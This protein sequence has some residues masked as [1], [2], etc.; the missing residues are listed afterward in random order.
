MSGQGWLSFAAREPHEPGR[1][2]T[3]LELL[4]DLVTVIAVAAAARGLHHGIAEGHAAEAI[5]TY[6]GAFFAIWWA[7]MNYTWFASAYGDDGPPFRILTMAMMAGSL[8]MAAGIDRFM[9]GLDLR[10]VVIGYIIMRFCM[11]LLW[12]AAARGD[13]LR[14]NTALR[15]AAGIFIAQLYW[16]IV[17]PSARFEGAA[18]AALFLL[19]IAIELSVPWL[20]EHTDPTP[21]HRHHI[22]ERYGLLMIIVFGE[23]LLSAS[24]SIGQALSQPENVALIH[25]PIGAAV[26]LFSLWWAYFAREEHLSRGHLG[27]ALMWGYGHAV[28]FASGAAVGAGIAVLVDIVSG[29]AHVPPI[30]GDFAVAIPVAILLLALWFVRDRFCVPSPAKWVFPIFAILIAWAPLTPVAFEGVAGLA[31]LAV[32]L[33]NLLIARKQA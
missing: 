9:A 19:G 3:P 26:I 20:A 11:V 29:R 18:F 21:W 1:V 32:L 13:A 15:Y 6:L 22:V 2:A 31:A 12:L 10:L 27:H 17:F 25:I 14:R 7:W 8:T 33:R 16:T 24:V 28:I 23:T 4:F 30:V 5:L